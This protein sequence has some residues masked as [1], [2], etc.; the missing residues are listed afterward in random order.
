MICRIIW[1][2]LMYGHGDCMSM[3]SDV[4]LFSPLSS[5]IM[6]LVISVCV[7]GGVLGCM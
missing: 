2:S 5:V 7:W 6:M 1:F 4:G 3:F